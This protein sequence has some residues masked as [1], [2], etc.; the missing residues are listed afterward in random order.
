M[1]NWRLQS[2]KSIARGLLRREVDPKK[3]DEL[4]ELIDDIDAGAYIYEKRLDDM[5]MWAL[6]NPAFP[7]DMVGWLDDDLDDEDDDKDDEDNQG[8]DGGSKPDKEK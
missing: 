2:A 3:R 5:E 4:R 7:G 1:N 8:T 6:R